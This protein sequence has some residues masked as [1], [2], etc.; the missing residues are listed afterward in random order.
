VDP[1]KKEAD[2]TDNLSGV[3]QSATENLRPDI[4]KL[5]AG[6]IERGVRKRRNRRVGQ[7]AGA[8]VSVTAVFGVVAMVGM[9]GKGTSAGVSAASGAPSSPGAPAGGA[10]APGPTSTPLDA[11]TEAAPGQGKPTAA[12]VTGDQM[13]TWLEQVLAPYNFTGES[14]LYKEGSDDPA[15]PYATVR[16]GYD[17]QAGSVSLNVERSAYQD[18]GQLPPY[19][20]VT[21]LPDGSH[22]QVFS[23][24]EWPAGNG[25]PAAKRLDV[26]WYR[27]DGTAVDI[28]V[29]NAVQEK[30]TTTATAL[31]LDVGQATKAVES[32]V[33]NKAIAAVLAKPVP[34]KGG[35]SVPGPGGVAGSSSGADT[36]IR[37]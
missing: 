19:N 5:T 33:W 9:P 18:N 15:G 27:T 37:N 30:G 7:I 32:S 2:V 24:P 10:A 34:G 36:K 21:L 14:V 23:G 16:I 22:L 29:L 20:S 13:S 6:G 25:D 12:P 3:M 8:A 35:G 28:E 26:T 4:G 11:S 31:G 1:T 17:G